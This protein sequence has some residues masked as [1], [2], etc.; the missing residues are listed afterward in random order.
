M[1][2]IINEEPPIYA[3]IQHHFH[4]AAMENGLMVAYEGK[5]YTWANPTKDEIIHEEVH[6]AQQERIGCDLWWNKY[7]TDPSFRLEQEIEAYQWQAKYLH[8]FSNRQE[9]RWR[10]R[11]MAQ[12]LSSKMYG[13]LISYDQALQLLG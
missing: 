13:N 5:I 12:L 10:F 8:E 6:L 9:R 7:F 3:E 4:G 2:K 11:K 1:T